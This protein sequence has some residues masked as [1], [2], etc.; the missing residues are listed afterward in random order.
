MATNASY[1]MVSHW[2]PLLG[3]WLFSFLLPGG[4]HRKRT[5]TT[6]PA[7]KVEEPADADAC[8]I[9]WLR[10]TR[11]RFYPILHVWHLPCTISR[12]GNTAWVNVKKR[13]SLNWIRSKSHAMRGQPVASSDRN[14]HHPQSPA[15]RETEGE[16]NSLAISIISS[17]KNK[18]GILFLLAGR[19]TTKIGQHAALVRS[20]FT[21]NDQG[22]L[23]KRT[24]GEKSLITSTH[25]EFSIRRELGAELLHLLRRRC[26]F[27]IDKF[28]GI[29]FFFFPGWLAE[30]YTTHHSVRRIF[31]TMAISVFSL[32]ARCGE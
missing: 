16:E 7:T 26:E 20:P 19:H 28:G 15:Q 14:G 23:K 27:K 32:L 5:T 10:T 30:P 22:R 24:L 31:L 9:S 11:V 21:R 17:Q 3:C 29:F 4:R 6:G 25:T 18:M 1:Y 12:K 8:Y 2:L 13:G